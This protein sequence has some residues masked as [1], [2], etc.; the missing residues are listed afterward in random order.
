MSVCING[1]GHTY[2][3]RG[4]TFLILKEVITSL[5]YRRTHPV[6]LIQQGGAGRQIH[7]LL[8][9]AGQLIIQGINLTELRLDLLHIVRRNPGGQLADQIFD[10]T[11]RT[12]K[13][14]WRAG[15]PFGI[16]AGVAVLVQAGQRPGDAAAV[17]G[18]H[19]RA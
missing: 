9:I 6:Y 15:I 10:G 1:R 18:T 16:A 2:H 17:L 14:A 11:D 13:R 3:I 4:V 7:L 8:F 19:M 5:Q 12:D